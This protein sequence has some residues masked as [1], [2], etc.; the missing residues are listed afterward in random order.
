M[1]SRYTYARASA[2]SGVRSQDSV[3]VYERG[4]VLVVVVADGGGGM[5]RGDAASRSVV[6]VVESAVADA[7]FALEDVRPW[8]DLFL[9]TD[10]GL[11]ANRAGETTGAVVVL[12]RR[13]FLGFSIGNSEAWVVTSTAVDDLTVGQHTR[14]RLGNRRGT[15]V[16]FERPPLAGVLLVATDG[17]FKH[18]AA[19]VIAGIARSGSV[20][21]AADGLLELV[22]LRSGKLADDVTI[23]LVR[24][25]DLQVRPS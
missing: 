24:P 21:Q 25:D 3:G 1:V 13:G 20:A 7:Q 18:A 9:A 23:V 19:P 11:V 10:A 2:A 4:D 6:A 12:G 16:S 22:R 8:V 14:E 15:L 5:R 17:L